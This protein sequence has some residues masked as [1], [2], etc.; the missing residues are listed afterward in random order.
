M[1][2]RD[3]LSRPAPVRSQLNRAARLL[4]AAL[5][6][7]EG[8]GAGRGAGVLAADR[9]N[10]ENASA[11]AAFESIRS[12]ELKRHIVHLAD[13]AFEG[14]EAGSRGGRAAA[15]Y[16]VQQFQ[17]H[18]LAGVGEGGGYFQAFGAGY[19]NILGVLQGSDPKL[20][21]EFVVVAA[22]FDHVGYGNRDNSFGPTGYIHNGADDNAS[23]TAGLLEVIEA[24]AQLQPAPRRSLLFALWDAEEK[25]LLGSRHWVASPTVPLQSVRIMVNADMIGRLRSR[26]V[27][28]CGTRTA[29]GLRELVSRQNQALDLVLDFSWELKDNSDHYPFFSRQI[30]ILMLHTGLHDDYHRPTDDAERINVDGTRDVSRLLF[31]LAVELANQEALPPFR[32]ASRRET[33]HRQRELER[34]L[35]PLP[36]RLGV[37]WDPRDQSQPGLRLTSVASGSPA[38]QAGLQI[39]DWIAA[40]E[41]RPIASG[42]EFR[43]LVLAAVGEVTLEVR[44]GGQAALRRVPVRL[45][46]G[47]VRFG[48][49]WRSDDA[50]PGCVILTR[51]VPGSPAAQAGLY[52]NDRIY[53][54]G[55]ERVKS[56][57]HVQQLLAS[58]GGEL[59][60]ELE[61]QGRIQV[62]RI[63][64]GSHANMTAGQ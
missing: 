62:I 13:D 57:Q 6:L 52:A 16:L 43:S 45:Q 18:N 29:A 1:P 11:R 21:S 46:G 38:E 31:Q 37:E 34:P 23:G 33:V 3:H 24:C 22:H 9:L 20:R 49:S 58:A 55:G 26:K 48:V 28:V 35:P 50:E 36:G 12:E 53:R 44:R 10:W 63:P 27:E 5:V 56:G 42:D 15:G 41:G 17:K 54:V 14:R 39:G 32:E 60:I 64:L 8:L 51:I 59:E 7:G 19:R 30:P 2:K 25:G 4:V 40:I 47:P 61:R